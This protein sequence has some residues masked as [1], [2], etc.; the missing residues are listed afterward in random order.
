[1]QESPDGWHRASTG[2]TFGSYL[3]K[4]TEMRKWWPLMA[5]C[6][7]SFMLI[8]DTTVVT[9][10]LPDMAVALGASLAHLQW[11]MNIYTLALG[12]LTLSAGSLGDIFGQRKVFVT[13]VVI[14]AAASLLCGVST[15]AE[16]LIAARGVQ[17]IGGAAM[18][19]T[20]L[21]VLGSSYE[22]KE[23][24]TAIGVWAG[25]LG[26]AAAA[27]PM[28]GGLLTQYLSWRAIFFVNL[29]V[30]AITLV[31]ALLSVGN[32]PRREGVRIDLAGMLTF[33]VFASAATYGLIRAGEA[34]DWTAAPTLVIFAVA[35]VALVV[36]VLVERRKAHPML[37][38]ALF[39]NVSFSVI[40]LCV[41]A[42]SVSF[43]SLVFTS[44]W[45]QQVLGLDP[46]RTGVALIPMALTSFLAS[47]FIGKRLLNVPPKISIGAG[48]LLIGL[49]SGVIGLVVDG[50]SSWYAIAPGLVLVGAGVGISGP[51][52]NGAVLASVPKERGGMASGAMATFRQLGQALGVAVLGLFYIASAEHPSAGRSTRAAAAAGIDQVYLVTAGLSLV[53]CVLAFV[54]IRSVPAKPAE[55]E[56]ARARR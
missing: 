30:S 23:R 25:V 28:L 14:F 5:V 46:L 1:M 24:G 20:T 9:V 55:Q 47:T 16:L 11:V 4:G 29:P 35:V 31:L 8:V 38:V 36:F 41:V 34:G 3:E 54:A 48:L 43:A 45:L 12:V 37:D 33:A 17:G 19:G 18:I 51:G 21:A 42:T 6:L 7:G 27:G 44:I 52:T 40:M 53:A 22:G 13:S 2:V 50:G 49:G 15:N 56:T 26:I 32:A 10:A 39:R